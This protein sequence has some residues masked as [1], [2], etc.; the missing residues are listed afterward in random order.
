MSGHLKSLS[1]C[2]VIACTA[3]LT[4]HGETIEASCTDTSLRADAAEFLS[5]MQR[6]DTPALAAR[7]HLAAEDFDYISSPPPEGLGAADLL[8]DQ[9]LKPF[10]LDRPYEG[11]RMVI[12]TSKANESHLT[13]L[14]WLEAGKLNAFL[15][16]NF[17]CDEGM[18]WS[19]SAAHSCFQETGAPFHG[20]Y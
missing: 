19:I 10:I 20:N 2:A 7:Y 14:E 5:K 8:S 1:L 18:G 11:E 3:M 9:S 13:D 4:A 17:V 15:V 12:F 16:C 6:A